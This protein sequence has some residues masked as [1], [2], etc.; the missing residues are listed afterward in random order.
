MVMLPNEVLSLAY[1]QDS[2]WGQVLRS[3][4]PTNHSLAKKMKKFLDSDWSKLFAEILDAVDMGKSSM[5]LT[6]A[7]WY[8]DLDNILK[9]VNQ[10]LYP[11]ARKVGFPDWSF[12]FPDITIEGVGVGSPFGSF[13]NKL[14]HLLSS[15]EVKEIAPFTGVVGIISV[16][17][18]NDLLADAKAGDPAAVKSLE[19]IKRDAKQ[20][21]PAAKE[22]VHTLAVV[23]KAQTRKV[24]ADV[25]F[26]QRGVSV[27]HLPYNIVDVGGV[28]SL[29]HRGSRVAVGDDRD[30]RRSRGGSQGGGVRVTRGS[31]GKKTK[32]IQM[33]SPSGA[34][35]RAHEGSDMYTRPYKPGDMFG[36][37]VRRGAFD[38]LQG[39]NRNVLG[40]KPTHLSQDTGDGYADAGIPVPTGTDGM[41]NVIDQYG[42]PMDPSQYGGGGGY[43]DIEQ[44]AVEQGP[45]IDD[46][47]AMGLTEED[48]L[49]M[50]GG[51]GLP[52]DPYGGGFY[53]PYADLYNAPTG[54]QQYDPATDTFYS[55]TAHQEYDPDTDA[56]YPTT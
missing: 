51:E 52:F 16:D 21:D 30:H 36:D 9:T 5:R 13:K 44:G 45:S 25:S 28:R 27:G 39:L 53:D 34:L 2:Q 41:G 32:Y 50:E 20:G 19:D 15:K 11:K 12:A 24:E 6:G 49:A 18:A 3:T 43:S 46:L 29:F 10:E 56:F 4:D 14:A 7:R 48:I 17:V 33:R 54:V 40:R 23:D 26:Y 42:N 1:Q 47:L 55:D 8:V 22:A 38:G 35:I 31:S 37:Y